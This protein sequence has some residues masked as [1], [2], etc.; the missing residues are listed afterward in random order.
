MQYCLQICGILI[1]LQYMV[2]L[3]WNESGSV[4]VCVIWVK[5]RFL[6]VELL[7]FLAC[8][9]CFVWLSYL[10]RLSKIF[11]D[12]HLCHRGILQEITTV[13]ST[14]EMLVRELSPSELPKSPSRTPGQEKLM[15]RWGTCTFSYQQTEYCWLCS[16]LF[17]FPFSLWLPRSSEPTPWLHTG[18]R[19]GLWPTYLKLWFL[20]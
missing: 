19:R 16:I 18:S 13:T 20:P 15:F 1:L 8:F 4:C 5:N 9:Q 2:G 7:R 6:C 17:P 3:R 12:S 14:I 11:N 10:I